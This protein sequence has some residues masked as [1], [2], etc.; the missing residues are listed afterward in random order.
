M[1]CDSGTGTAG[2]ISN[3]LYL[4]DLQANLYSQK[5]AMREGSSVTL[6]ADGLTFTVTTLTGFKMEF[7]FD[8]TF[9]IWDDVVQNTSSPV[10]DTTAPLSDQLP[11][12]S[13]FTVAHTGAVQE[14]LLLH[15]RMG[16]LSYQSMLRALQAGTWTGFNHSIKNTMPSMS[17][18]EE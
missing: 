16:H 14:F 7:K 6:S 11:S 4:P 8:G 15:F 5:Q 12:Q 1:V 10:S 9:W 2:S 3:V 18:H 17:T 13:V